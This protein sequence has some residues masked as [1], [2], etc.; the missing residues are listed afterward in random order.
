MINNP[1][2][3]IEV[4][5]EPVT[6][7]LIEDAIGRGRIDIIAWVR[8]I[9]QEFSLDGCG[10]KPFRYGEYNVLYGKIKEIELYY[11]INQDDCM[12]ERTVAIIPKTREVVVL[13]KNMDENREGLCN[14]LLVFRYPAG[15]ASINLCDHGI[16]M[17]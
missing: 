1:Q 2:E 10:H 13:V 3:E 11:S 5:Q 15:W 7:E 12:K 17:S 4:I 14:K 6:K 8:I 16:W 9:H